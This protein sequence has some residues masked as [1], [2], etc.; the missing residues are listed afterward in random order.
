MT[1]RRLSTLSEPSTSTNRFNNAIIRLPAFRRAFLL[2]ALRK[3]SRRHAEF[4][5]MNIDC[6]GGRFSS[7]RAF[8]LLTELRLSDIVKKEERI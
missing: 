1:M 3:N 4:R 6:W 8:F 7:E 2:I 5:G